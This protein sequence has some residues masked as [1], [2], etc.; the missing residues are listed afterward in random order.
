[1]R[2]S[3]PVATALAALCAAAAAFPSVSYGQGAGEPLASAL[4]RL[5]STRVHFLYSS[6]LLPPDLKVLATPPAGDALAQARAMLAPHGLTIVPISATLYAVTAA[7]RSAAAAPSAASTVPPASRPAP[8]AADAGEPLPQETVITGERNGFGLKTDDDALLYSATRLTAQPTLGEDALISLTRMPG[9]SQGDISGRINIRGGGPDETLILLDGFPLRQPWHMPGYRGVLSIIDPGLLRQVAVY[10][11]ALPARYGDRM[12]GV[13]DLQT[14]EP[15]QGPRSSIG[16]GFLNARARTDFALPGTKY[17]DDLLVAGRYGTTG[18]LAKA[19]QP[20]AGNPHYGDGYGRLRLAGSDDSELVFNALLSQDTLTIN[21]DGLDERSHMRSAAGYVWLQGAHRLGLP[22]DDD[23]R[24][25]LWLGHTHFELSRSGELASPGLATGSLAERRSADLWDF[26]SRFEWA[27]S[28]QHRLESGLEASR[29]HALYDYHSEV[30]HTPALAAVLGVAPTNEQTTAIDRDRLNG[31]V[32]VGDTWALAPRVTGQFGLRMLLAG[33]PDTDSIHRSDPR[34]AFAWRP[35]DE[36]S[37]HAGWG[38]VHQ[39]RDLTD[40]GPQRDPLSRIIAQRTEYW[41]LGVDRQ[42]DESTLLRVESF[43]KAQLYLFPQFRNLLRSAS[44]LPEL[45]ID[46]VWF[47]PG[48]AIIRGVEVTLQQQR[49]LWRWSAAW[50]LSG[51]REKY[52]PGFLS[53]WD[54][55]QSGSVSLEASPGAWLL[56]A[57]ANYRD[58]LPSVRF[59]TNASGGLVF[60]QWRPSR[61]P[62]SLTLDLRAKWHRPLGDGVLSVIG[63]VSNLFNSGNCCSEFAPLPGSPPDAPQLTVRRHGSLP[64]IPY[65]GVSWDF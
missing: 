48:S 18:Y 49:D 7:P 51:R 56:S 17:A 24:M 47:S 42:I 4:R 14:L 31:A 21:R 54:R 9:I 19:M 44:I 35:D 57:A 15:L 3:G 8:V 59:A 43:D 36:T 22:G 12:S 62:S 23:G 20:A 63:Q 30:A 2:R 6:Q 26:R 45:S 32:F 28:P 34:I 50:A 55:R 61:L 10:Q 1:M 27:P 16:A 41:M 65:F 11:G 60:D 33:G 38:R 52:A 53:E 40:L 64:A 25:T 58:G 39:L 37:V 13:L 5:E 46:R 29:G